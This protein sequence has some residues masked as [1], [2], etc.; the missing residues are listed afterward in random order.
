MQIV[1]IIVHI[2]LVDRLNPAYDKVAKSTEENDMKRKNE[3]YLY[4][5]A[6]MAAGAFLMFSGCSSTE[7]AP[8]DTEAEISTANTNAAETNNDQDENI[9]IEIIDDVS[10]KPY[11]YNNLCKVCETYADYNLQA[12]VETVAAELRKDTYKRM[13]LENHTVEKTDGKVTDTIEYR[14]ELANPSERAGQTLKAKAVFEKDGE[15]WKLS[16]REWNEWRIKNMGLCGSDWYKKADSSAIKN[17][18]GNEVP[19]DA[20]GDLYIHFKRN[21]YFIGTAKQSDTE[22]S[23]VAIGTN[24]SGTIYFVGDEK[25][26]VNFKCMEGVTNEDGYISFKLATDNGEE[27]VNLGSDYSYIT[28]IEAEAALSDEANEDA[29]NKLTLDKIDT[30]NVSSESIYYGEYKKETGANNGNVSPELTWDKVEGASKYAI[31]MIDLDDGIYHLHWYDLVDECSVAEGAFDK[32]TG[33]TGPY[34][35]AP[36]EYTIY[37]FALK[38]DTGDLG[39]RVDAQGIDIQTFIDTLEADKPGNIISYGEITASYE[40]FKVY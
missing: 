15:E 37:V 20:E 19:E 21:I 3:R 25:H 24:F 22:F 10:D 40:F 23:D 5:L 9:E 29:A 13:I 17:W 30:F 27:S 14:I 6:S 28:P 26:E 12:P 7:T 16:S 35:E 33:F 11:I 8:A 34:P 39:L 4:L 38:E 1:L 2:F 36:H 18:F 32:S 31:F